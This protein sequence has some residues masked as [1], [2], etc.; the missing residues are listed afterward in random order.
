MKLKTDKMIYSILTIVVSMVLFSCSK[1]YFARDLVDE[2][3]PLSEM[4]LPEVITTQ[5]TS[6]SQT[7]AE[8]GGEVI[9]SGGGTIRSA[10]IV[11]SESPSPTIDDFKNSNGFT[12]GLFRSSLTKL[13]YGTTYYVR[14]YATND[15]GTS[16][17]EEYTFVTP[18]PLAPVETLPL[19]QVGT[20]LESSG[21]ILDFDDSV[22]ERGIV[23]SIVRMPT[24]ED[25]KVKSTS[26]DI[27]F[28]VKI[29][30]IQSGKTYRVRAYTI[31]PGGVSYG[32][33]EYFNDTY[34]LV[35]DPDGN[36]YTTV[37]IG[38]QV[39]M[40]ENYKSKRYRD[41][42]LIS[43]GDLLQG[44]E[45]HVDKYGQL[46]SGHAV[47]NPSN[48]AP[49]GWRVPTAEDWLTLINTVGGMSV[50][51]G[52]LKDV[53][54]WDSPNTG[55]TNEFGFTALPGGLTAGNAPNSFGH[56]GIWWSASDSN[57]PGEL[58]RF[59]MVHNGA[60]MLQISNARNLKFSVRLVKE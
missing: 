53:D 60:N 16:Y 15:K 23:W 10:G 37:N 7:S 5:I 11:W 25:N 33:V 26:S 52:R 28:T 27:E 13:H 49:E 59:A 31:T 35:S 6:I 55:A 4:D 9:N 2:E 51:G 19:K 34:D 12:K 24:I 36:I 47:M 54:A 8:G 50:A 18:S 46:Y 39:W 41:G 38:G 30:N 14:A 1:E 29:P 48:L 45:E 42:S 58:W 44:H 43:T 21:K 22:I 57:R 3:I 40:G 17:G 32:E 56:T 20:T